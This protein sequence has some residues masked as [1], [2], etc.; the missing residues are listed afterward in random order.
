MALATTNFEVGLVQLA[1]QNGSVYS[2]Q[3]PVA[4]TF[5]MLLGKDAE[6]Q[7]NIISECPLASE[8]TLCQTAMDIFH[9]GF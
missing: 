1:I 6:M 2:A 3:R 8:R 7:D 4:P 5:A 9:F